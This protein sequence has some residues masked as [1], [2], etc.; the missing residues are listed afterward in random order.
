M[1]NPHSRQCPFGPEYQ[2]FWDIRYSLLSKFD[3]ARIDATGLY[4][5]VP[6]DFA[7][8]MALRAGGSRALDVCS[9]IGAMSIAL[10]RAGQQVTAVEIDASRVEMARHNA[11]LYDVAHR[12]EFRVADITAEATLREL[13][14]DIHTLFLDPPWGTG[15]GD[16]LR[17]PV[18]RLADLRLAGLDLR[19]LVAAIT[20]K[21]VMMRLPPNFDIG[22]VRQVAGE[23]LA[24]VTPRGYLHWYFVRMPKAQFSGLPD[25]SPFRHDSSEARQGFVAVTAGR[26]Q[27]T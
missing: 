18:T 6:E 25:R 11:A 19:E 14:A 24:Y 8:D 1:S 27:V 21:E 23:K 26:R 16:Y 10:A 12:I 2:V 9:G 5:M 4:T 17:R 20:C 22:I 3:E 15:P 13:P 7:L